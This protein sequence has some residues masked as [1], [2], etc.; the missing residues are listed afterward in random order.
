MAS[1]HLKL[2]QTAPYFTNFPFLIFVWIT[3]HPLVDTET[4]SQILLSH[5]TA[6]W[7]VIEQYHLMML[8]DS[9]WPWQRWFFLVPQWQGIS[10]AGGPEALVVGGLFT[11]K[12]GYDM[13]NRIIDIWRTE[14][15]SWAVDP[16]VAVSASN[17]YNMTCVLQ[18]T[19]IGEHH[20]RLSKNQDKGMFP[21]AKMDLWA[22]GPT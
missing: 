9:G 10:R 18:L 22:L 15:G 20:H 19:F 3:K 8:V 5:G 14:S 2:N 16:S 4:M 7:K 13:S 6:P 11:H 17:A 1:W 21:M 12:V